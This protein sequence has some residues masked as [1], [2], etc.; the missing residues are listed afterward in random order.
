MPW[1]STGSL[2]AGAGRVS[3]CEASRYV[4]STTHAAAHTMSALKTSILRAGVR[5]TTAG[6]ATYR[7]STGFV[8]SEV[9]SRRH[10]DLATLA[11]QA[12]AAAARRARRLAISRSQSFSE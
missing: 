11:A 5:G 10:E 9:R 7:D 3:R 12:A 4:P 1:W 2:G 8:D 6:A